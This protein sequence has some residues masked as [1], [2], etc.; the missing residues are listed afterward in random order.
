MSLL[1]LQNE[2]PEAPLAGSWGSPG[3]S[4]GRLGVLLAPLGAVLASRRLL[5]PPLPRRRPES[6]REVIL[7]ATFA[8]H[9]RGPR[10]SSNFKELLYF[11]ERRFVLFFHV[12]VLPCGAAGANVK[13]ENHENQFVFTV[14]SASARLSRTTRK[15][16]NHDPER[17]IN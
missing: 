13:S 9:A 16:R 7:G 15:T 5:A 1:G 11:S 14:R 2:L 3:A 10:E 8:M 17:N 4:W 6:L 12:V